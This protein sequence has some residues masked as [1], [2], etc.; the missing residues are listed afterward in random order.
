MSEQISQLL[1]AVEDQ[2]TAFETFKKSIDEQL[3]DAKKGRN[4]P[5]LVARLEKLEKSMDDAIE[6]KSKIEAGLAAEKKE[7]EDL[8]MRLNRKGATEV[9]KEAILVGDFNRQLKRRREELRK[10]PIEEVDQKGYDDY[11][12]AQNA[13]LRNGDKGMSAEELKT[14]QIS[15]DPDGGYLVTPDVSGRIVT[16][17][18]ETS[19][20]RQIASVS[21]TSKDKVEGME[22]LDE[23]GAGYAGERSTSGNTDTPQLGKWEIPIAN[24]DTEPKA[25]SNLLDDADRDVEAWLAG[26]VSDKI[27]RFENGEFV[28]GVGGATKIRGFLQYDTAV[29][30]GSGVDWG[31][32]G[33]IKTGANG[34]FNGTN[35]ADK[36]FDLIGLLKDGYLPNA[37]FVTRR[38]VI[39]L[40]RK[41]KD[42]AGNYLWQPSLVLGNPESF[43]AYPITRAEDMPALSSNGFSLA[44]GDFRE[45]YSI[46]DRQGIRVL[47]DP[48]TAKPYIKFYTTKRTGGGVV[49]SEAIKL[50]QFAS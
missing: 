20:I 12:A 7:R 24:I 29:D 3:A 23:A 16:K 30:S 33:Y 6:L 42:T 27:G 4:D 5:A 38:A 40:M 48:F 49:N 21:S 1:K 13:Y 34:A 8:E 43:A 11:K 46:F 28:N 26:K 31:S 39:T 37:R 41:F 50:L 22:D 2:G 10:A 32:I 35:P 44:F 47:R 45:G 25:T 19:P 9:S 18:Y 17:L 15:I 36:I 14:L